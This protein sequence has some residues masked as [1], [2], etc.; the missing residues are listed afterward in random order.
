MILYL[1]VVTSRSSNEENAIFGTV[2]IK[3]I[4]FI[5]HILLRQLYF[6]FI[7]SHKLS[8]TYIKFLC[9]NKVL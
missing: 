7:V 3:V 4:Y 9:C 2:I 8:R 5:V 6:E 1:D